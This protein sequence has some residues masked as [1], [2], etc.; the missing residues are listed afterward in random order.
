VQALRLFM[1]TAATLQAE[2]YYNRE[3]Q[4]PVLIE[5]TFS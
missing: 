1:D 4:E 3:T 5:V 2:D